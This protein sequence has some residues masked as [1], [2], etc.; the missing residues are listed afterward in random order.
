[1]ENFLTPEMELGEGMVSLFLPGTFRRV[2]GTW[3]RSNR[4]A[5]SVSMEL[6]L[7]TAGWGRCVSEVIIWLLRLAIPEAHSV[8]V[9]P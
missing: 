8:S 2:A 5:T 1:M 6:A 9:K 3:I 4:L 7:R